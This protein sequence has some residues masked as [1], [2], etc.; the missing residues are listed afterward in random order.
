MLRTTS[1]CEVISVGSPVPVDEAGI[2]VVRALHPSD[3]L[4]ADASR[5]ERHD[6]HQA[7]LEFVARQ[8]GTDES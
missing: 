2:D 4:Q 3:R 6:V 5:L 7:V 8:V 1:F